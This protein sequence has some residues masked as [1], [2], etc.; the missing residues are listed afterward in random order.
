MEGY[1]LGQWAVIIW[2]LTTKV[3]IFGHYEAIPSNNC[4][5]HNLPLDLV[6]QADISLVIDIS[7]V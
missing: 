2:Q 6:N 3:I 1:T 7:E 4:F 5:Y